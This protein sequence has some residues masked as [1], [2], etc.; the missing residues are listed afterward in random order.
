VLGKKTLENEMLPEAL[1]VAQEKLISHLPS[2]PDG[3]TR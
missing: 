2:S 1:K 3:D